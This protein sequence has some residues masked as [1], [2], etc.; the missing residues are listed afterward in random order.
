MRMETGTKTTRATTPARW[1]EIQ[2]TLEWNQAN[3]LEPKLVCLEIWY[4]Q[5]MDEP[6]RM[7]ATTTLSLTLSNGYCLFSEPNSA[8]GVDHKHWW[9]TFWDKSLGKAVGEGSLQG[10]GSYKRQFEN[11]YAVY[12][13]MG[14][15]QVTV[16]FPVN[17]VRV[18]T[19]VSATTHNVVDQ[20]GDIF[21]RD[22]NTAI[23]P[24]HALPSDFSLSQNYPN[25]FRDETNISF[26][27][28]AD[29][30]NT[31]LSVYNM[32]GEK[33]KV[34]VDGNK[35]AGVY[36]V[37]WDGTSNEGRKMAGGIYFYKLQMGSNVP[38]IEKKMLFMK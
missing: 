14:N 2:N 26:S 10:N 25:P 16:T 29:A 9:W 34:L 36:H 11:G 38:P 7:R 6:S 5:S 1:A 13:P 4:D 12:N 27:L 18:S 33:V 31:N 35:T 20:D 15:G 17:Y 21:L 8:P 24:V 37:K 28:P 23:I 19:G 3:V 30:K 32:L 22:I